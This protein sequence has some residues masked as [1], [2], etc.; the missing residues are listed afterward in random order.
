[1]LY[2]GAS[3]SRIAGFSCAM[4]IVLTRYEACFVPYRVLDRES[5][6]GISS[7]LP[8]RACFS[9]SARL[10]LFYRLPA[11]ACRTYLY[12]AADETIALSCEHNASVGSTT[13]SCCIRPAY[14]RPLHPLQLCDALVESRA[15]SGLPWCVRG[16]PPNQSTLLVWTSSIFD[17]V[18]N[19]FTALAHAVRWAKPI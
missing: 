4:W 10:C 17:C 9:L 1:M 12:N 2:F 18:G 16:P 6:Y 19:D 5:E 13:P 7:S 3:A 14:R 8:A 15:S 11:H